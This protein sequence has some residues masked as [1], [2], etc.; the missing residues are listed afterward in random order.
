MNIFKKYE[1]ECYHLHN[2]NNIQ[3]TLK[4]TAGRD[5]YSLYSQKSASNISLSST[6]SIRHLQIQPTTFHAVLQ[7]I[8]ILKNL[9]MSGSMLKLMFKAML[10]KGQL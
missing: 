9:Y 7:Y 2:I 1:G 8:F 6:S 5:A 4:H 10:F 3:L